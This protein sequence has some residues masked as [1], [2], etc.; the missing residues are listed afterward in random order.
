[1]IH[2]GVRREAL[3]WALKKVFE[4]DVFIKGMMKIRQVS[5][6]VIIQRGREGMQIYTTDNGPFEL[7]VEASAMS[8]F[9]APVVRLK[10]MDG[11]LHTIDHLK[12]LNE[13]KRRV[14]SALAKARS[15]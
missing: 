6:H 13:T 11:A 9:A 15:S 5:E 12:Q 14:S 4:D 2:S 1:M 10:D 7:P 3:S 8:M